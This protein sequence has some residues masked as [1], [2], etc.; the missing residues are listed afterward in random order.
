MLTILFHY[1]T[2]Q[3]QGLDDDNDRSEAQETAEAPQTKT[4][5]ELSETMMDTALKSVNTSSYT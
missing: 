1:L 5:G 4:D 3:N 2:E